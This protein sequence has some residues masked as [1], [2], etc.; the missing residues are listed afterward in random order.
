MSLSDKQKYFIALD[1]GTT[2]TRANIID[3]NFK[4][5][6][7]T[8]FESTLIQNDEGFAELDPAAY[9]ENIVRRVSCMSFL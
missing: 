1:L 5:V 8:R 3:K 9:W 4:I 6:A 7:G 2:S